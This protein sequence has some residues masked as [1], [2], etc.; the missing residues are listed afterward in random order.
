MKASDERPDDTMGA[1][2]AAADL[3]RRAEAR[4]A[5]GPGSAPEE[6][7]G[8]SGDQV[9]RMVHELKVHQIELEMQNEELR[10]SRTELEASHERYFDLFDLA[11]V[12]YFTLT[13][14]ARILEANLTGGKLLGVPRRGLLDRPFT[15]FVFPDDQDAFY[16]H[17]RTVVNDASAVTCELRMVRAD[18]GLFHALLESTPVRSSDNPAVYRTVVSDIT[19]RTQAAAERLLLE[20]RFQQLEKA[21]SLSRMAGAMTHH[22][23][24]LLGVITGN[25][26][27]ALE[28]LSHDPGGDLSEAVLDMSDALSGARRAT[29]LTQLLLAYLG[30]TRSE[31]VLMDLSKVARRAM[32]FLEAAMPLGT[33]VATALPSC[34]PFVRAGPMDIQQLLA[35][36]LSNA[37]EASDP[38]TASIH[39]SVSTVQASK[40]P[41]AQRFPVGW[42]PTALSYAR[43]EVR[44]EGPGIESGKLSEI[45]DPF[46]SSK[47]FGR[48]LGLSVVLGTVRA[49]QGGLIVKTRPGQGASFTV[50]LPEADRPL[51]ALERER[52][53]SSLPGR[54]SSEGGG[55]GDGSLG[56]DVSPET[57]MVLVVDDN[58]MLRK[59]AARILGRMGLRV[60]EAADGVEAVKLFQD[61]HHQIDVVLCDVTMPRM[62]GWEALKGFR[63]IDPGVPVILSSGYDQDTIS[64]ESPGERPDAFLGKP[65]H[66]EEL[67]DVLSRVVDGFVGS[68]DEPGRRE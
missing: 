17:R 10:Q 5:E 63:R 31:Q 62:G 65:W 45:F 44:D 66:L 32:A 52:E 58:E 42:Q 23:N 21:G 61:H 67:R 20:N 57:T 13:E 27:L 50:Y 24:N 55:I 25:L 37:W 8:L 51:A 36:L 15:E 60:M 9:R 64:E 35:N 38:G 54:K 18:G 7:D 40:I 59:L 22:F 30:Q 47:T 6:L 53:P 4:A 16:H 39:L 41:E 68:D 2:D 33:Q 34:G 1:H 19:E 29:D 48:G 56:K 46:F 3:R 28:Q 49:S 43:I 26:E 14:D 12:G 11:P